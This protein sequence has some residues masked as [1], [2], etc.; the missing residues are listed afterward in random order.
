MI[1]KTNINKVLQKINTEEVNLSVAKVKLSKMEDLE[2]AVGRASYMQE[3]FEEA[4]D[5][6]QALV[7]RA[8]DI[9]RFDWSDAI[10]EA[11]GALQELEVAFKELGVDEPSEVKQYRK[12]I[13]ELE[14]ERVIADKKL[15]GIG[16]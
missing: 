16:K 1:N 14:N 8:S 6:A 3:A 11:E 15:D 7:I 4:Y 13:E 5:D 12:E 9:I 10:T 2:D